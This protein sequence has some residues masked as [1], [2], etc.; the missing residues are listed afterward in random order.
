MLSSLIKL[1]FKK[2]VVNV[3]LILSRHIFIYISMYIISDCYVKF[4]IVKNNDANIIRIKHCS[5][6]L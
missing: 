6:K 1:W 2:N 5:C 3:L 4:K